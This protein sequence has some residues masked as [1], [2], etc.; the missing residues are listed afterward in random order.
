MPRDRPSMTHCSANAS[1][2]VPGPHTLRSFNDFRCFSEEDLDSF[3]REPSLWLSAV[4]AWL[5][6]VKRIRKALASFILVEE[7]I[8]RMTSKAKTPDFVHLS[9]EHAKFHDI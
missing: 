1:Y 7:K 4:I 9:N 3:L 5:F 2:S 8:M 6:R